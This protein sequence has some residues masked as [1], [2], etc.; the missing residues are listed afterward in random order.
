[1]ELP[2]GTVYWNYKNAINKMKEEIREWSL[3][4]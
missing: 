2:L 4:N 1:M 3:H